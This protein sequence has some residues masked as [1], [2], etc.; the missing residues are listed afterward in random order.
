MDTVASQARERDIPFMHEMSYMLVHG[1]LHIFGYDHED[2]AQERED[3]AGVCG[4]FWEGVSALEE[5]HG[6]RHFCVNGKV[7]FEV[8]EIFIENQGVSFAVFHGERNQDFFDDGFVFVISKLEDD[9]FCRLAKERV[10]FF[11]RFELLDTCGEEFFQAFDFIL[12]GDGFAG[13]GLDDVDGDVAVDRWFC[14]GFLGM[15]MT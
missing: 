2:D 1:F 7:G 10:G 5:L 11:E 4:R 9:A 3:G 6:L 15:S 12:Y 14:V 13:Q 8:L